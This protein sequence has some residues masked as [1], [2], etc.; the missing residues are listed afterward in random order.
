MP[1]MRAW[2]TSD[3]DSQGAVVNVSSAI[4]IM[5]AT[6]FL[7]YGMAKVAQDKLT[8]DL[9]FEYA[10]KGLRINSVLPGKHGFSTAEP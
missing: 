6:G 8:K 9:A 3:A 2:L 10:P 1:E 5:P 4:A 7:T